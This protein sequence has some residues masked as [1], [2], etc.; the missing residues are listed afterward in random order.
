MKGYQINF[1][2]GTITVT[3]AFNKRAGNLQGEEYRILEKLRQDFPHMRIVIKEPSKRRMP[4]HGQLTYDKILCYIE[5]QKNS[6]VLLRE[7]SKAR[8]L[9]KAQRNPYLYVRNWFLSVFPNYMELPKFDNKGTLIYPSRA[10]ET[11]KIPFAHEQSQ[12][13]A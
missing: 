1:A 7:F 10:T 2:T 8:E 13:V 6:D 3:K 9:S 5:N 11:P 12:E 4:Q